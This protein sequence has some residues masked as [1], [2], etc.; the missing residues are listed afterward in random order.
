LSVVS[1]TDVPLTTTVVLQTIMLIPSLKKYSHRQKS[2]NFDLISSLD[3]KTIA[4]FRGAR[5]RDIV[6]KNPKIQKYYVTNL[7]QGLLML[8]RARVD[9]VIGPLKPI[10][11]AAKELIFSKK[12]FGEPLIV[13]ER[14][15]WLHGI[16][17]EYSK[18][19]GSGTK[20]TILKQ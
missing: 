4:Y 8:N 1:E 7:T 12:Y 3:V 6:D 11:S 18:G 17:K 9:G 16:K 15:P 5:F 20:K 2:T 19:A 13:F 10:Y 14:V